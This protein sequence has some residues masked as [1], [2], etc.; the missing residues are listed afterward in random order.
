MKKF[1]LTSLI[2]LGLV[3][4]VVSAST[5]TLSATV[6]GLAS[7]S[8]KLNFDG[9]GSGSKSTVTIDG[10][11]ISFSGSAQVASGSISGVY[12][13]PY[14]SGSNGFGFGN[15]L[16]QDNTSYLST[17]NGSI[18]FDFSGVVQKYF[19]LLWGSVDTYNYVTFFKGGSNVGSFSGGDVKVG[20]NGDQGL[21]GTYY[22]DFKD[23]GTGFDKVVLSSTGYAFELDNVA[24]NKTTNVP[25]SSATLGL[26]ALAL[27]GL[28]CIRRRR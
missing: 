22:V 3:A 26:L 24:F 20:A 4:Q 23:S 12:A 5:I 2:A 1:L 7:G 18:A 15:D 10:A 6:G 21:N 25:D 17:G 14:I 19:G 9:L 8:T 16:G 27:A 13:A 11:T 28:A